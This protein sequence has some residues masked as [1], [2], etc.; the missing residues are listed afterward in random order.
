MID[1][2]RVSGSRLPE[3]CF[4]RFLIVTSA[5]GIEFHFY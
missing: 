5:F 4:L 3:H 1:K 2:F